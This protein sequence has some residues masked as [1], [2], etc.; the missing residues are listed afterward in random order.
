MHVSVLMGFK[1]WV[2][3]W[4]SPSKWGICDQCDVLEVLGGCKGRGRVKLGKV[5]TQADTI[6]PSLLYYLSPWRPRA[7]CAV[8]VQSPHRSCLCFWT[9]AGSG[10]CSRIHLEELRRSQGWVWR[11]SACSR[12]MMNGR[13]GCWRPISP[14]GRPSSHMMNT[15]LSVS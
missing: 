15:L 2:S 8:C 14:L 7:L 12:S 11:C 4:V 3:M 10:V 6:M 13:P 1:N 5:V 9:A